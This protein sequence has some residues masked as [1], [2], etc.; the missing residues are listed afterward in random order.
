MKYEVARVWPRAEQATAL[1]TQCACEVARRQP[2]L[3]WAHMASLSPLRSPPIVI[4][5]SG[6]LSGRSS[7]PLISPPPRKSS[8]TPRCAPAWLRFCTARDCKR[9]PS[10][11]WLVKTKKKALIG[12]FSLWPSRGPHF[13]LTLVTGMFFT[14]GAL[15]PPMRPCGG[16]R[17]E[18][19]NKRHRGDSSPCGQSPM[20]F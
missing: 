13:A 14:S 10:Q 12:R 11:T 18:A 5:C 19:P 2:F 15:L 1:D 17:H 6:S 3:D 9:A 4:A 16:V 8:G 20:D 7:N